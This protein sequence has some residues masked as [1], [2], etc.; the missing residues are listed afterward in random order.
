M[1]TEAC[2]Y[3]SKLD[4]LAFSC[5][6]SLSAK[7]PLLHSWG[8]SIL[9]ET[10]TNLLSFSL[11]QTLLALL[12]LT[13]LPS[14]CSLSSSSPQMSGNRGKLYLLR[15]QT[16]HLVSV[17][18]PCWG[19]HVPH[20]PHILCYYFEKALER[21]CLKMTSLKLLFLPLTRA[22]VF[23]SQVFSSQVVRV[24]LMVPLSQRIPVFSLMLNY[25][26]LSVHLFN[27]L[28]T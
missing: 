7:V 19:C 8:R 11:Y 28:L 2:P 4:I 17:S 27:I 6:V 1:E 15:S 22:Y 14:V 10:K 25:V 18:V 5:P 23:H 21:T 9:Q 13:D 12:V 26:S 20:F 16:Q 3:S 24:R